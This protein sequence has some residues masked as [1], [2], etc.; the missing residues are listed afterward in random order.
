MN[1]QLAPVPLD[2]PPAVTAGDEVARVLAEPRLSSE[3]EF[4][5]ALEARRVQINLSNADLEQLAGLTVGH[6]SKCL[7]AGGPSIG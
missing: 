4:L 7:S 6:A 1:L 2:E 3:P 5:D